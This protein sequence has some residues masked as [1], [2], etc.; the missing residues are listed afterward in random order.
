L[1]YGDRRG[2]R[3]A[4][5]FSATLQRGTAGWGS[6]QADRGEFTALTSRVVAAYVANHM[7]P[8]SELPTIIRMVHAALRGVGQAPATEPNPRRP[9]QAV[10]R[11]GSFGLEDGLRMTMLKRHLRMAH[12]LKPE[13][14]RA[15]WGLAWDYAI[16]APNYSAM[17]SAAAR[18]IEPGRSRS[19]PAPEPPS[20][21]EPSPDSTSAAKV[22]PRRRK[23]GKN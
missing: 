20:Q 21:L 7:L 18:S 2:A 8:A 1:P 13:Q 4:K 5:G 15:R 9:D 16:V 12:G 11:T 10:S 6:N 3:Q 23:R 22:T 17:R 19:E 14:Y